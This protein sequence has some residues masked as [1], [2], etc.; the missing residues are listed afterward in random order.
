M[1]T[2]T[3]RARRGGCRYRL[4]N[5]QAVVLKDKEVNEVAKNEDEE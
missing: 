3:G 1:R 5:C 2:P 4:R